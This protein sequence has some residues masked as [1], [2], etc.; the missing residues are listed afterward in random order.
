MSP[1]ETPTLNLTLHAALACTICLLCCGATTAEVAT[2]SRGAIGTT[3]HWHYEQP[4][5]WPAPIAEAA[6]QFSAEPWDYQKVRSS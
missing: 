1:R 4:I 3:Y 5:Y 6:G 2:S